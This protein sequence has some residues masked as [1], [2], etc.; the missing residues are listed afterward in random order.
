MCRK[1]TFFAR[2]AK[3]GR[4]AAEISAAGRSRASSDPKAAAPKAPLERWKKS[5]RF[6]WRKSGDSECMGAETSATGVI[7]ASV[8][9]G[10]ERMGWLRSTVFAILGDV[11]PYK[12]L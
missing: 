8:C 4:E 11:S 10:G 12:V 7:Y 5:R 9:G 2:G 1:I 6:R 3:C